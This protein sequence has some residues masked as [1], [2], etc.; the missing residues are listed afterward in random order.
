MDV[1]L[2]NGF[3]IGSTKP[4]QFCSR[5]PVIPVAFFPSSFHVKLLKRSND[6]E[7]QK[8][9][10]VGVEVGSCCRKGKVA[11]NHEII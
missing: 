7:E 3:S 10:G 5:I 9:L 1:D 8:Q 4:Q 11:H 6:S 2:V